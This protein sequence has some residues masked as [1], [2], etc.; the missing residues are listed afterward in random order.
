MSW[1]LDRVTKH[2]LPKV[3]LAQ[4]IRSSPA[5]TICSPFI[6]LI[7]VRC[8]RRKSDH[9]KLSWNTLE[10]HMSGYTLPERNSLHLKRW[11]PDYDDGHGH[12]DGD[13][14]DDDEDHDDARSD[15]HN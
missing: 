15:H 6:P 12:G 7:P 3:G 4:E 8:F 10:V 2:K 9:S 14:D 5:S 11:H 13:D 1:G